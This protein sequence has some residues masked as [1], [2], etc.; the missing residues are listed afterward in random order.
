MF[1][2]SLLF[3]WADVQ[4][5]KFVQERNICALNLYRKKHRRRPFTDS[6]ITQVA[7]GETQVLNF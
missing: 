7:S 6:S 2:R 3:L 4:T 5:R 1:E